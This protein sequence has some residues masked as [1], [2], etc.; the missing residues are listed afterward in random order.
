MTLGV[1]SVILLTLRWLVSGVDV[2]YTG[3]HVVIAPWSGTDY[4]TVIGVW[5]TFLAQKGW[6][7]RTKNGNGTSSKAA[8]G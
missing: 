1:P 5:L 3:G 7:D 8:E 2:T 6:R 4:A